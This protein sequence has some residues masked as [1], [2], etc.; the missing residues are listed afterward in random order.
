MVMT[1]AKRR[2]ASLPRVAGLIVIL[3]IVTSAAAA[4]PR[5][6]PMENSQ[7]AASR[8]AAAALLPKLN[9]EI[10]TGAWVEGTGVLMTPMVALAPDGRLEVHGLVCRGDRV[11]DARFIAACRRGEVQGATRTLLV[12]AAALDPS[13]LRVHQVDNGSVE[14]LF[15]C[16]GGAAC[17]TLPVQNKSFMRSSLI[18]NDAASCNRA[19]I[20]LASLADFAAQPAT[21]ADAGPGALEATLKRMV[22]HMRRGFVMRRATAATLMLNPTLGLHNGDSLVVHQVECRSELASIDDLHFISDCNGGGFEG[23]IVEKRTVSIDVMAIDPASPR[24]VTADGSQGAKGNWVTFGCRSGASCV[25]GNDPSE[26]HRD[27]ILACND[28][29]DCRHL[30]D[31]LGA[32]IQLVAARAKPA[33]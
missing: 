28:G 31:D 1:N 27:G 19:V 18:C 21:V 23:V 15:A 33:P 5:L 22:S 30:V 17:I 12:D 8:R 29:P 4:S 32:L 9:A 26:S 6:R 10:A 14:A 24:V 2:P 25:S 20:D 16:R 11:P 3:L 13:S 7:P